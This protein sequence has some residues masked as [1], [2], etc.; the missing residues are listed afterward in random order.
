MICCPHTPATPI[1]WWAHRAQAFTSTLN[2]AWLTHL[3]LQLQ[4]QQQEGMVPM[5]LQVAV[6][7]ALGRMRQQRRLVAAVE[8]GVGVLMRMLPRV[9]C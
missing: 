1:P 2:Q 8:V 7:M 3:P 5:V 4:Q 6:V 9:C